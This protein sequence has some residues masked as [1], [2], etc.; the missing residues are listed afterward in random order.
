MEDKTKWRIEPK[1]KQNQ[2]MRKIEDKTMK[3][4]TRREWTKE[5]KTGMHF[6]IC[7][8]DIHICTLYIIYIH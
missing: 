2:W 6:G 3:D 7:K 1:E 5:L 4:R 8:L